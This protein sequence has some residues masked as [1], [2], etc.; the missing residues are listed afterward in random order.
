[1]ADSGERWLPAE[2]M[3]SNCCRVLPPGEFVAN[4]RA[5]LGLS[6]WCR[7]CHRAAT[8]DWRKRNRARINAERRA[9]YREEHPLSER[10]CVVCGRLFVKR[11]DALVCADRCRWRRKDERRR[12][13]GEW[14]R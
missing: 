12:R 10:P 4:R 2:K 3:C 6:S 11:P 13:A 8:A 14:V 9:A 5:Y 1:M 7:G